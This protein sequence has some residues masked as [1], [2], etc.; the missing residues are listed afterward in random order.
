M[1]QISWVMK[2]KLCLALGGLVCFLS[3]HAQSASLTIT[4]SAVTNDFRGT[5]V[6]NI[7][8][9]TSGESITV[10][11]YQDVNGNGLID[12]GQEWMVRSFTVT[13]GQA[14]FIGGVRNVNVPGDEDGLTNGQIRVALPYPGLNETISRIAANY[15][16]RIYD[17]MGGFVPLT[18][19]FNIAQKIYPQ[20]ISGKVI[21]GGT[22]LPIP[23][24][25]VVMV[26]QNGSGA[27]AV[28]DALGNFTL[29]NMP[30]DYFLVAARDGFVNDQTLGGVT[31][32][33]NLFGVKNLTNLVANR[34]LSG[35]V[36]DSAS[37]LGL[38]GIFVQAE[39]KGNLF[40]LAFCDG[41]GNFTL[42]ATAEE[43]KVK[44][45]EDSGVA[46]LGYV[47]AGN[48]IR[49]NVTSGSASNLN[50]QFSKASALIYGAVRDNQSNAVA[51]LRIRG[52]DSSFNYNA[53]GGSDGQ[54]NYAVGAFASTWNIGPDNY[55]LAANNLIGQGANVTVTNWQALRQDFI[56]RHTTAHLRGRAIDDT[57]TPLGNMSLVVQLFM[58]SGP[59]STS[60]YPQ[61]GNDGTFDAGVF[62]G[63]WN[64]ALECGGAAALGVVGPSLNF[65]VV[66]GVDQSNIVLVALHCPRQ[67]SG[68]VHDNNGTPLSVKVNASTTVNGTNYNSCG[69]DTDANGNY[70]LT[71]FDAV[72]QVGISGDLTSRG[73]DNPPNQNALVSGG[74]ATAN[75]T[76][77]PL[78]QSPPSLVQAGYFNGH[79]QFRLNGGTDRK[80]RI[81][82]TTNLNNPAAWVSLRTNTAFGGTF[83]FI[84]ASSPAVPPRFYRAVL[85][86]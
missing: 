63:P 27:G 16:Y 47:A 25:V 59:G 53:L 20:G 10:E 75:I 56:V 42:P 51:N 44:V 17:P 12:A 57:G 24:P 37:G 68:V 31:V 82:A 9:L 55:A 78:G 62:A 76:V 29:Y 73:Y 34:T 67:I 18:N 11:Q 71:A 30:G 79:F 49:T 26:T 14:S 66:N 45:N 83:D 8:G 80:Y 41:Q 64:I 13:D 50:F 36:T 1:K 70:Q 38:P 46:Q 77:F 3:L 32:S 61:T 40:S 7:N 35:Q 58:G 54:G 33:S 19:S 72:W 15:L 4:P 81:D 43:W 22:G 74:T 5:I 86:P 23:N 6:L 28:G 21:A 84:D 2:K 85:V 52:N 65:N 48:S 60:I 39:T 69:A